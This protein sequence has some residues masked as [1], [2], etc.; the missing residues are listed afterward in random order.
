[1]S[2]REAFESLLSDM[3]D[4]PVS[5]AGGGGRRRAGGRAPLREE[6]IGEEAVLNEL[7][8]AKARL[9]KNPGLFSGDPDGVFTYDDPVLAITAYLYQSHLLM[10]SALGKAGA[11]GENLRNSSFWEWTRTAV[12]TWLASG[13]EAYLTLMG[14]TPQ[15][16]VPVAGDVMRLAVVGDAGYSGQAQS[17]VLYS[18]RERHRAA[19]FHFLIHL[20]DIYF[21]GNEEE[22]LHHFLA[23]FKA[24]GP[25]VLTLL[26]NH[27]LY[28]GGDAVLSTLDVLGQPGRYFCLENRHWRVACLDTALPAQTLRRNWGR[29]DKGQLQWLDRQLDAGDGKAT[30]LMSHHHILS[31]WDV[32][33][34]DLARQLNPRLSKVFSWYWGHEH[35]CATYDK[36]ATGF[37]GACVGNG[38]YLEVFKQPHRPTLPD[39]YAQGN[40]TCYRPQSKFW[41]HGYLELE[42]HPKKVIETY[43]LEGGDTH[44][45]V[46]R[47]T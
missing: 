23:P 46:L 24:V 41:R 27:D 20:G 33:S 13:D 5:F 34:A 40:C 11:R 32:P 14:V 44:E 8:R 31:G 42:L 47:R 2:K 45:R 4:A 25:P 6:E 3:A 43:H 19:A 26:G 7:R 36:R 28:L 29:L 30:V 35:G 37:Y 1:M 9:R 10:S 17:N 38:A 39:W 16:A 12:R 22:V 18:I 21:A 15:E